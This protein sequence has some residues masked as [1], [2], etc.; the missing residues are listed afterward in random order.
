MR[1]RILIAI[2]ALATVF[3][4]SIVGASVLS[5]TGSDRAPGEGKTEAACAKN[6]TVTHPVTNSGANKNTITHIDI[7][8]DM[9]LCGGQTVRLEVD[10]LDNSHSYAFIKLTEGVEKLTFTFNER[11]GEF[12]DMAPSVVDGELVLAG[13]R[14]APIKAAAF[15]A[16]NVLIASTWE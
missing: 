5:L 16:V 15:D 7:R 13:T 2:A 14:I 12:T 3:V 8:G 9:T 10:M 4:V 11:D 1:K 6:L